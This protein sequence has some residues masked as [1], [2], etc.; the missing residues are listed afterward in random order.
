MGAPYDPDARTV[1]V[2]LTTGS[3]TGT[4]TTD[5]GVLGPYTRFGS[6]F[7]C[8]EDDGVVTGSGVALTG[9]FSACELPTPGS[10]IAPLH[11]NGF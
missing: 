5:F 11:F 10:A 7:V 4:L 3:A 8:N 2:R 9:I 1:A 6:P